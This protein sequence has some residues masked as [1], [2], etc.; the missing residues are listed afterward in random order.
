MVGSASGIRLPSFQPCRAAFANAPNKETAPTSK[1][2]IPF[3]LPPQPKTT[4]IADTH[5]IITKK[6]GFG[7]PNGTSDPQGQGVNGNGAT[8]KGKTKR[9]LIFFAKTMLNI[10]FILII[11]Y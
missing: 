3:G 4:R 2:T 11:N 6:A 1:C 7:R 5:T 10:Y 9:I 8:R